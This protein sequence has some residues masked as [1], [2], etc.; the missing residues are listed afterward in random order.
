MGSLRVAP[1]PNPATDAHITMLDLFSRPLPVRRVQDQVGVALPIKL[2]IDKKVSRET[3]V[4]PEHGM[5]IEQIALLDRWSQPARP[6]TSN[7][8]HE[9]ILLTKRAPSKCIQLGRTV[10]FWSAII[11]LFNTQSAQRRWRLTC[12]GG[13]D[14]CGT[15]SRLV[16]LLLDWMDD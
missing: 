7:P 16:L 2:D 12:T 3:Q 10:S 1:L 5:D 11:H 9:R 14:L 6:T 15:L 4:S 13:P 8:T